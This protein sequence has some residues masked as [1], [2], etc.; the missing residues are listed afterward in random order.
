MPPT[1][2]PLCA[3]PTRP[4][5]TVPGD[6]RR[7]GHLAAY[8]LVWCDRCRF[9]R[10]D[11]LPA[12]DDLAAA[13]AV[14]EYYTHR[15]DDTP[16]APATFL[17]RLRVHLAWR[18]DRGGDLDATWFARRFGSKPRRVLDLGCGSG[19][20]LAD[21]QT[22]GHDVAGVEPDGRARAVAVGRGLKVYPGTA[23]GLPPEMRGRRFD[24]VILSH[25]LEHCADPLAVVRSAAGLLEPGGSLAVETPNNA[26]LGLARA[27]VAWYFLDAPRHLHFFTPQSLRTVCARGGLTVRATEYRGY[28]RQFTRDWIDAERHIAGVFAPRLPVH[29]RLQ[30]NSAGQ[31]W[32]LLSR[33]VLAPAERKYDSVRVVAQSTGRG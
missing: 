9:G 3:G 5:L 19:G 29:Q 27:G 32:W 20:V 28:T 21:L 24:V 25:V 31:A 7:P 30:R 12:P 26:A 23:E 14:E 17:E 11:P 1:P 16:A 10:I 6:W 15:P 4:W 33:T 18:L 13:Y 22:A 2:C 8:S